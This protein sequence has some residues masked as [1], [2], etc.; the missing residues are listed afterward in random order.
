MYNANDLFNPCRQKKIVLL[1]YWNKNV[2]GKYMLQDFMVS[3]FQNV[4]PNN[5][6]KHK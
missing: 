6:K 2:Y 4:N 3:R 5:V 1:W